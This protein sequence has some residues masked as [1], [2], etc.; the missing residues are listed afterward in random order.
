VIDNKLP[1]PRTSESYRDPLFAEYSA[2]IREV[3]LANAAEDADV[4]AQ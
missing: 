2:R 4:Y 1:R 3:I